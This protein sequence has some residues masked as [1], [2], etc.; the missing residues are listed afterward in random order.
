M[1][2]AE[3]S[4]APL[5]RQEMGPPDAF[6]SL[7]DFLFSVVSRSRDVIVIADEAGTVTFA[8]GAIEAVTG[9]SA[10]DL[11]DTDGL[12]LIHP[13]DLPSFGEH[14]TRLFEQPDEPSITQARISRKDGGWVWTEVVALN[15]LSDPNVRGLVGHFRDITDRKHAELA[16]RES[17][18]RFRWLVQSGFD[19]LAVIDRAGKITY[20]SPS[21]ERILGHPLSLWLDGHGVDLVHPDD[22]GELRATLNLV[23]ATPGMW[24]RVRCRQR[25]ANG[26]WRWFEHVL[27]NMFDVPA[28]QGVVSNS[29]DTTDAQAAVEALRRTSE[30]FRALVRHSSDVIIVA[31][32]EGRPSYVSPALEHVLGY[33]PDDIVGTNLLRLV[34]PED[35]PMCRAHFETV[36]SDP[37]REHAI[38]I[39]AQHADGRWRWFELRN[40]NLLHEPA[41]QGIVAHVRD[42]T[43]RRTAEL[44]LEYR[45]LHDPLT[46]LPNRALVIDRLSQTFASARRHGLSTG[47][48]FI[49]LDRFKSVNDSL[50]HSAGDE[51]LVEVARRLASGR[52][53][54]DTVARLGGDEFVVV[55]HDVADDDGAVDIARTIVDDLRKP[56]H[57]HGREL[58]VTASLGLTIAPG[59]VE[60]DAETLLH[61]ADAAM[62]D[63]K[64]KG[65]DRVSMF[66]K[67]VWTRT[68]RRI[69]TEQ[70]LRHAI[71]HD[72]LFLEYQPVYDLATGRITGVEALIRWRHPERG[73]IQPSEFIPIAESSELIVPI[74]EWVLDAA[75]AQVGAWKELDTTGSFRSVWVNVSG[76]Q[77]ARPHFPAVVEA[78]LKRYALA[79][80]AL[81][82]ELTESTLIDEAETPGTELRDIEALGVR[83]AIDDFGTGYS[84]LLYLLRFRVDIL[85]IDRTFVSGLGTSDESTAIIEAVIGLAH[86]LGMGVSAE[87]VET[88]KQLEELQRL[89][90]DAACGFLLSRP[91]SAEEIS[92]ILR[93]QSG[94]PGGSALWNR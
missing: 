9:W 84:S 4:R 44:A 43:D 85:K 76:R 12:H 58:V 82:L 32:A 10:S 35:W 41:V 20:L 39:R 77:L 73:L 55:L 45:A 68:V 54:V 37:T 93:E 26:S 59:S 19:L 94:A 17:E 60:A 33:S 47:V 81:G 15:L 27:T 42:I 51:L 3:P 69:E 18:E 6:R 62:Y 48:L 34:H 89:E 5:R 80:T 31:D 79:S 67:E 57:I 83:V 56:F 1:P 49:D 92:R 78:A 75:C 88:P 66:D 21:H 72:E 71:D 8:T 91:V 28:V 46:G 52:R 65:G 63:A 30:R 40:T 14:L 61:E 53:A 74:G 25:H 2:R 7:H 11:L 29:R 23:R 50:G 16:L 24:A 86:T 90:C 87:G 36:V 64:S 13:D 22:I 38:E 70:A